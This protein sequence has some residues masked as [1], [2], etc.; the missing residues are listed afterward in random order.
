MDVKELLNKA[1]IEADVQPN[2][3]RYQGIVIH[4]DAPRDAV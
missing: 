1:G 4:T 2:E 3:M